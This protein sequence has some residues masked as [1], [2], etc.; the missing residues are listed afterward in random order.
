MNNTLAII[1]ARKGSKGV[2]HKN[3]KLVHGKPLIQY[4]IDVAKKTALIDKI[5][6]TTDDED[7]MEIA[8]KNDVACVSRLKGISKDN[9]PIELAISQVIEKY[10]SY[11]NICLL[12]PTSPLRTTQDISNAISLFNK[13]D[14]SL[15]LVSVFKVDDGHPSRMY[16]KYGNIMKPLDIDNYGKRRQDLEELFLRNGCMYIFDRDRFM[17]EKKVITENIISFQM[18]IERSINIDN[19]F[20]LSMLELFLSKN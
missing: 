1:P 11:Q 15:T 16:K 20:D 19:G 3:K 9:S 18:P 8:E 13:S 10:S 14:K 17:R 4:S 7:I 2:K 5:V 6:I 12:Q